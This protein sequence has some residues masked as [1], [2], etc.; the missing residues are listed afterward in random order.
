LIAVENRF[1]LPGGILSAKER[2][3]LALLT[4]GATE[5]SADVAEQSA[6]VSAPAL[7]NTAVRLSD[8][9]LGQAAVDEHMLCVDFGTAFSK[10]AL[11]LEGDDAPTPLDLGAAAGGAGLIE[12]STAYI[13]DGHIFFGSAASRRFEEEGNFARQQFSSP[14]EYLTHDHVR[15]QTHRP[16]AAVDPTGQFRTRDLLALFL[17]HLTSLAADRVEALGVDRHVLR[18]FAAPGWGD[19][20]ISKATP[21]FEVV[22]AQ[23]KHLLIDAQILADTISPAE[24]RDGIDVARAKSALDELALITAE[25]RE[26]ATFVERPV[27]EAVAA[28]TGVQDKL[29]NRRPQVLVVDV[30]AGTTDIGIF[31]YSVIADG[32]RVAAYRNGMR[33]LRMAGNR[34]DDALVE[35]AWS[36]LGLASDSQLKPTHA[37][38]LRL[39]IRDLKR[40]PSG[41]TLTASTTWRSSS[42]NL[43]DAPA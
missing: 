28:A 36:K 32:A 39:R 5:V 17:G 33:A 22:A 16:S 4:G 10:A 14:K 3:A 38:Q 24:W 11:W 29:I 23:L 34:L 15:F 42:W 20:Q 18:R 13:A 31:K 7:L 41:S 37:H 27:L 21:H 35:L 9:C 1:E 43:S 2:E 40:D 12:A 25:R 30:G 6:P 8:D 19:A 26:A